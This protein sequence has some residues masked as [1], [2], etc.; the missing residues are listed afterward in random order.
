MTP[1]IPIVIAG[2]VPSH[3]CYIFLHTAQPP[4]E[5]PA[6]I[7]TAVQRALMLKVIRWGGVVN[8]AWS[9]N[10]SA[11]GA[12]PEKYA[13]TAF[14]TPGGRF[15]IPELSLEN[16]DEV[17]R[18]LRKHVESPLELSDSGTQGVDLYV[19]THGARDCRCGDIGGEVV[20][21]LREELHARISQNPNGAEARVRVWEAGHV[22][23]HQYANFTNF[24]LH[25]LSL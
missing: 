20:K 3:R 22:G 24:L 10:L 16:V 15:D 8:F 21:A 9:P 25:L 23:G 13:A 4:K 11:L 18:L 7:S 14:S 17:E 2:T 19:C 1:S 5:F 12:E 6:R